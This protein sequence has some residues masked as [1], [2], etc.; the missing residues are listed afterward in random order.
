MKFFY[1]LLN[2][3]YHTIMVKKFHIHKK[4]LLWGQIM[5][6]IIIHYNNTILVNNNFIK[7]LFMKVYL[8]IYK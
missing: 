3:I 7:K 4:Q 5:C 1:H 6:D 2:H 8:F